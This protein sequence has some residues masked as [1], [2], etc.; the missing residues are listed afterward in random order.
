[1]F[2]YLNFDLLVAEQGDKEGY[3]TW[4][5]DHLYLFIPSVC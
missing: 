3:D 1:M 4:V 5:Y 2:I